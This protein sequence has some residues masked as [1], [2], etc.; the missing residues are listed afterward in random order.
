MEFKQFKV[1]SELYEK[2]ILPY[3]KANSFDGKGATSSVH[4]SEFHPL[5]DGIVQT[6]IN[7]ETYEITISVNK[8]YFEKTFFK[9][10]E[11][12]V[13]GENLN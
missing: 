13:K 3:L 12:L 5:K 6:D 8:A 7:S 10:L 2:K 1:S 4:C 11:K 9:D